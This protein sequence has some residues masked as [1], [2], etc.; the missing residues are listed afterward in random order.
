MKVNSVIRHHEWR[1]EEKEIVKDT[2]DRFDKMAKVQLYK[3]QHVEK[4]EYD[5]NS[6][7]R[8]SKKNFCESHVGN[9]RKKQI[10]ISSKNDTDLDRIKNHQYPS[11]SIN[12]SQHKTLEKRNAVFNKGSPIHKNIITDESTSRS[13][14]QSHTSMNNLNCID[15]KKFE[16][17]YSSEDI[18]VVSVKNESNFKP[19]NGSGRGGYK[20]NWRTKQDISKI[21]KGQGL[22][23][24]PYQMNLQHTHRNKNLNCQNESLN[25]KKK[26]KTPD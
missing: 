4:K 5:N 14:F 18:H 9:L 16:K 11:D 13:F 25:R 6:N 23:D 7:K 21:Q 2:Y 24:D 8:Y 15:S 12:I 10:N 3:N 22:Y 20:Q 17:Q 1:K 19:P 26:I